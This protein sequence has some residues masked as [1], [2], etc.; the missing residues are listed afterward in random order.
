MAKQKNRT[1]LEITHAIMLESHIPT[2]LWPEAITTAN[3]L[4]NKLP[5]KSL[6]Y[7]TPLETLQTHHLIP[8]SRSLPSRIFGCTVFVHC[9]QRVRNKLEPRAVK[10]VFVG[11]GRNQ[12]VYRCYDPLAQKVYTTMDCDFIE[13]K[14]YYRHLR[15][16][17]RN[18]MTI[19][20]G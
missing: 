1:L 3:C 19:S 10:C 15:C 2:H 13:T 11:Y 5:T 17:G 12:K 16:Q 9:P 6:H 18:K 8:S 7:N 14:F 20:D 4:S